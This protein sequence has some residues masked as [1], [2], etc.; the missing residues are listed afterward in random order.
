MGCKLTAQALL[1]G[2][3]Y[4]DGISVDQEIARHVHTDGSPAL[5]LA[6]GERDTGVLGHI[7]YTGSNQPVTGEQNPWYAY[8]DLVGLSNLF[9]RF[10]ALRDVADDPRE[11]A[12]SRPVFFADR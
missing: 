7:S 1:E 4:A 2:S 12:V 3:E 6:V 8:R 10:L 5:T 9:L 11:S